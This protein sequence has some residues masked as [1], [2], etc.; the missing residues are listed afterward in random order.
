MPRQSAELGRTGLGAGAGCIRLRP[1]HDVLF[2]AGARLRPW[3]RQI[4]HAPSIAGA[5]L[6][7]KYLLDR[8]ADPIC[9][10]CSVVILSWRPSSRSV[11]TL[12]RALKPR[13]P[14]RSVG[15]APAWRS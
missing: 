4:L 1:I 8:G 2:D 12:A 14:W 3:D 10:C 9:F 5:P 11:P 6:V 15:S 7:T 13:P